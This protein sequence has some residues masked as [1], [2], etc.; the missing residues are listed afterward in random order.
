V[1]DLGAPSSYLALAEGT[2]VLA[3][4]GARVGTVAEVRADP[5]ADIF[6]GLVVD[7]DSGPRFAEA[8]LVGEIFERGV[9]LTLDADAASRL[10][11][12]T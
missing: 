5:D 10:P 11:E 12:P 3:G 2:P 1:E 8:A 6:D 4:D 9:V 7:T